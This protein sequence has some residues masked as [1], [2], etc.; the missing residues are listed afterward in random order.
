MSPVCG[1]DEPWGLS[2]LA[3]VSGGS[4]EAAEAQRG[5]GTGGPGGLFPGV[6]GGV[7]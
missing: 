3:T 7:L 1:Q 5:V 4:P 2:A 6:T